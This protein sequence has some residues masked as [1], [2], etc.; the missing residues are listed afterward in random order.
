MVKLV[1]GKM[2]LEKKYIWVSL[3]ISG[4]FPLGN[5]NNPG[6]LHSLAR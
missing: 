6:Y 2:N 3:E 5:P 4:T 1:I